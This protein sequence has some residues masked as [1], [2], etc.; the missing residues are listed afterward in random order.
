MI[1]IQVDALKLHS[2]DG[3]LL[4]SPFTL[5]LNDKNPCCCIEGPSGS[6]K[7][8]FFKSL[9]PRFI[10]D[11]NDYS[12][13]DIDITVMRNNLDFYTTNGRIGYAAQR[14]YF[15]AHQT[16]RYNLIAPFSWSKQASPLPNTVDEVLSDFFLSELVDRKAYNLSAGERQR[17][18][19]ARMFIAKPDLVI[20]DES[21]SSMDE[22]LA[23]QIGVAI[24]EKYSKRTKILISGHR[25]SDLTPFRDSALIFSYCDTTRSNATIQRAICVENNNDIKIR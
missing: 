8:T 17:L 19:L 23:T 22:K 25:S 9:I 20:I 4:F 2:D 10:N 11:W 12:N 18:N 24:K 16:V 3:M 1:S 15:V 14:P 5:E 21:F 13:T 7:T 6:G